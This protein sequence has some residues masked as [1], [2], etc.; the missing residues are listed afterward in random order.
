MKRPSRE[1]VGALA[2]LVLATGVAAVTVVSLVAGQGPAEPGEPLGSVDLQAACDAQYPGQDRVALT[3]DQT[4][5][6]TWVCE[7]P[8]GERGGIEVSDECTRLHGVDARAVATDPGD[9]YSWICER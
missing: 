9:P 1:L 4:S 6:Y 3:L 8:T 7:S 2:V 5:A